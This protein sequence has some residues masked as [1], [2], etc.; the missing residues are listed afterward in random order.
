MLI[1]VYYLV[2]DSCKSKAGTETLHLLNPL[3][4]RH[5]QCLTYIRHNYI[6]L[7]RTSTCKLFTAAF[8]FCTTTN[9]VMIT[10]TSS[11]MTRSS[12]PPSE[13]PMMIAEFWDEVASGVDE[14]GSGVEV[15]VIGVA[16]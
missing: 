2:F 11:T 10:I 9:A 1:H 13:A 3:L 5:W 14:V 7:A 16:T 4:D 12:A 8:F 6:Y 15:A